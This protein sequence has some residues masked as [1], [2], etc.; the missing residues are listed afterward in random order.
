MALVWNT[1]TILTVKP[2]TLHCASNCRGSP[3][4]VHRTL[5]LR[6]KRET[7]IV[8]PLFSEE[9]G[10]K[11]VRFGWLDTPSLET[12]HQVRFCTAFALCNL[13]IDDRTAGSD[14]HHQMFLHL[15]SY[16]G[17]QKKNTIDTQ[18][19]LLHVPL[20]LLISLGSKHSCLTLTVLTV[21]VFASSSPVAVIVLRVTSSATWLISLHR[22]S[23][24]HLPP[25]ITRH[26][27][28]EWI[29]AS[30]PCAVIK[31]A[32]RQKTGRISLNDFCRPTKTK[33]S[34][35]LI[36]GCWSKQA[37]SVLSHQRKTGFPSLGECIWVTWEQRP[38]LGQRLCKVYG[39]WGSLCV[40]LTPQ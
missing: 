19:Q 32:R 34:N 13:M 24:S 8:K 36:L 40:R 26:R 2:A 30:G 17:L 37:A 12:Y 21:S 22:P 25:A 29:L 18:D 6:V 5:T 16:L 3:L 9:L 4:T 35:K 14:Y 33:T 23:T 10:V 27:A 38:K 39:H 11:R 28:R 7:P 31:T 15:S 20:F 1:S